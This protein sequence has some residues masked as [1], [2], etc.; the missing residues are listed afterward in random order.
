[1]VSWAG[2]G[3]PGLPAAMPRSRRARV[4][5][6]RTLWP[7]ERPPS[8]TQWL[9]EGLDEPARSRVLAALA[10]LIAKVVQGERMRP[11]TEDTHER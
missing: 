6:Q 7:S 5:R 4:E 3:V 10:R 8:A 11:N 2:S 9:W 1:M